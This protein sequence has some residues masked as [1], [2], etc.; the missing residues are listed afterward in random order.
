MT[1]LP[2]KVL[3]LNL[4]IDEKLHAAFKAAAALERRQMTDLVLEF[5]EQYVREHS[6]GF[7]RKGKKK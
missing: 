7:P 4:N 1:A 3:R 2:K 6:P 5:I